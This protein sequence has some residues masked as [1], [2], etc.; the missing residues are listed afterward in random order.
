[1]KDA[2]YAEYPA[3]LVSD[4]GNIV[5]ALA[6]KL[7]QYEGP[8][9]AGPFFE[10]ASTIVVEAARSLRITFDILRRHDILLRHVSAW[11]IGSV[12]ATPPRRTR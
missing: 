10:W 1:L 11:E 6:G 9:E 5:R 8:I 2:Y 3:L 7:A 12:D 4:C